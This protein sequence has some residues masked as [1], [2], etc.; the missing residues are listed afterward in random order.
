[1]RTKY[2]QDGDWPPSWNKLKM[3]KGATKGTFS[4]NR[5][6]RRTVANL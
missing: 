1:M 6:D 3:E 5:K 2:F 4:T